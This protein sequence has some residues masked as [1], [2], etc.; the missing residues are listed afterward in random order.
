MIYSLSFYS[1]LH[2]G[3]ICIIEAENESGHCLRYLLLFVCGSCYL[4]VCACVCVS[5]SDQKVMLPR[6][7]Y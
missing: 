4:D 3:N 7:Y 5:V 1:A 2:L 6:S